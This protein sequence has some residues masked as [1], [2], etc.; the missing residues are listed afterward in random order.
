MGRTGTQPRARTDG[1]KP[2]IRLI[3]R[4]GTRLSIRKSYFPTHLAPL[5]SGGEQDVRHFGCLAA[6]ISRQDDSC[7]WE[8]DDSRD[9]A[10]GG[11][12][13]SKTANFSRPSK[14]ATTQRR[15]GE[16][17]RPKRR[18]YIRA[19]PAAD[20]Q[21]EARRRQP[22]CVHQAP[23]PTRI[24]FMVGYQPLEPQEG[25]LLVERALFA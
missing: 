4:S 20:L 15:R 12:I 17:H 22:T 11:A 23:Y 19:L 21:V 1:R 5:A 7:D 16:R 2:Q 10:Q 25:G 24:V 14:R 6:F 3:E 9:C 13:H 8:C 18:A